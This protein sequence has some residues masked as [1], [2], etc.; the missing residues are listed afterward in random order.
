MNNLFPTNSF[1]LIGNFG[2]LKNY[3]ETILLE[4]NLIKQSNVNLK[5]YIF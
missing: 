1:F 3:E 2:N 5:L 4:H